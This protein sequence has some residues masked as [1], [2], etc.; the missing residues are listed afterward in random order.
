MEQ[1]FIRNREIATKEY[2]DAV[3]GQGGGSS[4]NLSN[5]YTKAEVDAL[6]TALREEFLEVNT[7][8]ENIINGD[9]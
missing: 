4:A 1:I 3:A 2:V 7:Q 8:L 9:E 6:I 5:Y